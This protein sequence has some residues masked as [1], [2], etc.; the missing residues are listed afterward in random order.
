MVAGSVES[1]AG[2][3]CDRSESTCTPGGQQAAHVPHRPAREPP[4]LQAGELGRI[5]RP[6]AL[7]LGRPRVQQE[8]RP[9]PRPPDDPREPARIADGKAEE[10][11][12]EAAPVAEHDLAQ[13]LVAATVDVADHRGRLVDETPAGE[14]D[15]HVGR[16]VLAAPRRRPAAQ[17]RVEAADVAQRPGAE[18]HARPGSQGPGRV[19]EQR[20]LGLPVGE[21]VDHAPEALGEAAVLL[22]PHLGAGLQ[23]RRD[24][25]AGHAA[26]ALVLHHRPDHRGRPARIDQHVVVGERHEL[27]AWRPAG[28]GCGP[29]TSPGRSSR[30]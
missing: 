16:E 15:V 24:H 21:I 12:A 14:Q 27:R 2:G 23:L 17:G 9:V 28:P 30:R 25:Q 13:R 26:D 20:G 19:R 11:G 8:A 3:S 29:G 18:R 4:Q 5:A 1:P 10:V 7:V 22:D 6:L